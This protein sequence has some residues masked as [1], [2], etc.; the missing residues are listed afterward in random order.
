MDF[1]IQPVSDAEVEHKMHLILSFS[2]NLASYLATR[3]YGDDLRNLIVGCICVADVPGYED[4]FQIGKPK[5]KA[6]LK[7][8]GPDGGVIEFPKVFTYDFKLDHNQFVHA[9]TEKCIEI[10]KSSFIDSLANLENLPRKVK[11]FDRKAFVEDVVSF[12]AV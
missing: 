2:D 10:L 5:Y 12:L 11:Q 9:Q 7:T 4:W 6:L 8:R 3:E 1:S